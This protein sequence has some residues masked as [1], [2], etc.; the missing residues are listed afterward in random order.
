MVLRPQVRG[1]R[2]TTLHPA[3][4]TPLSWEERARLDWTV[5]RREKADDHH[6]RARLLMMCAALIRPE[7][8]IIYIFGPTWPRMEVGYN[9]SR[10]HQPQSIQYQLL[11]SESRGLRPSQ[12]TTYK[13][14]PRFWP[15]LVLNWA[16]DVFCR[17][18]TVEWLVNV[19]VNWGEKFNFNKNF[20]PL[21]LQLSM[22]Y[23]S[24]G[25]LAASLFHVEF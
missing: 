23:I 3:H 20:N 6:V 21:A 22:L 15:C 25:Y 5:I 18:F 11:R 19:S 2:P 12:Q 13:E 16:V 24:I 9:Y 8:R 14:D 7:T 1:L 10:L 17:K 4:R